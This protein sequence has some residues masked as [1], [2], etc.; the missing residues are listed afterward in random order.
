MV[1]ASYKAVM[2]IKSAI[3]IE[4]KAYEKIYP[5]YRHFYFF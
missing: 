3:F 2:K 1:L 4:V 5:L